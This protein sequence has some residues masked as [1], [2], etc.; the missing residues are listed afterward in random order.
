VRVLKPI[1]LLLLFAVP[2]VA[3]AQVNPA[4]PVTA[5]L[6]AKLNKPV[7]NY[8]LGTRSPIA[9]LIK[10]SKDYQIPMGIASVNTPA[11]RAEL[12]FSW[13]D[14]T[15]Q[16]VI[17]SIA[18]TLGYQVALRNGV[19]HVFSVGLIPDD[20]NFLKLKIASYSVHNAILEVASFKLRSIIAPRR[21]GQMSIAGSGDSTLTLELTNTTV[22][23]VLDALAVASTGKIWLVTF[24]ENS[25]LTTLPPVGLR[26]TV[27][28]WADEPV[29]DAD[30]PVW[31]FLRWGNPMP[32]LPPKSSQSLRTIDTP[33]K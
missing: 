3:S 11:A 17:E 5:D 26:R 20:E 16:D 10:V 15:V 21:Y 28:L 4:P 14:G 12:P 31:H 23:D 1:A 32:P 18:R 22:E 33:A 7:H 24:V 6:A 8:D 13:P 9:A 19:V 27:S 29:P 2:S 25:T 30:L